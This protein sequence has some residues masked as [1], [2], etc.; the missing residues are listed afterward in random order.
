M[1]FDPKTQV[2][3][4]QV[5]RWAGHAYDNGKLGFTATVIARDP[6]DRG[7]LCSDPERFFWDANWE[8]MTLIHDVPSETPKEESLVGTRWTR[9]GGD[10]LT[11]REHEGGL[12]RGQIVYGN[13][14][15]PA[16]T[17]I[18]EGK[19]KAFG[20]TCL[21]SPSE[22][23]F[24]GPALV[25]K[26]IALDKA[27]QAHEAAKAIPL[28]SRCSRPPGERGLGYRD[29][30][31]PCSVTEDRIAAMRMDERD[32]DAH[33]ERVCADPKPKYGAAWRHLEGAMAGRYRAE[34]P[35]KANRR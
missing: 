24:Y 8:G 27:R 21:P 32:V 3:I 15:A 4:G 25:D 34:L 6:H 9:R 12:V 30:C 2:R 26:L 33:T 13:G 16:G 18:A 1:T 22:P 17:A 23:A 28:C 5:W 7:W 20:W 14:G 19:L 29:L 11:I 31:W 35:Y 10:V